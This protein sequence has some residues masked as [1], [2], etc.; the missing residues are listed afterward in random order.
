M[1]SNLKERKDKPKHIMAFLTL[2]KTTKSDRR[3][4][5]S[6]IKL[7]NASLTNSA[8]SKLCLDSS[9]YI[10]T[11]LLWKQI[12]KMFAYFFKIE[13]FKATTTRFVEKNH[14]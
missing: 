5:A 4:K 1:L 9:L 6:K 13:M 8:Q 2:N 12:T 14:Y 3:T 10:D 11:R 7:N